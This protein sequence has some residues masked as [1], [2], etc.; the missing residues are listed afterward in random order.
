[1]GDYME[2]KIIFITIGEAPRLDLKETYDKFFK[3]QPNVQQV[4]VL[5]GLSHKQAEELLGVEAETTSVLTSRFIDGFQMVMDHDKVSAR[6][7]NIIDYQEKNGADV[8]VLLCT[9][10][11]PEITTQKAHLVEGESV[12]IPFVKENYPKQKVGVL[13]PLVSQ[14]EDSH[15]KWQRKSETYFTAASPYNFNPEQFIEAADFFKQ[16]AVEV[17]ILDCIGFNEKMRQFLINKTNGIEV[18]LSN[19]ILFKYIAQNF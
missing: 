11:F 8:I 9:G 10:A 6:L 13:V 1:M 15:K 12:S 14:V 17:I 19:E 4:G 18:L 3:G 16:A 5:N 7:Q 2:N